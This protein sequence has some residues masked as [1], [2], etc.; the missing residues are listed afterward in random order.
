MS[1]LFAALASSQSP[2]TQ[3]LLHDSYSIRRDALKELKK[4]DEKTKAS[5][6][7]E[8]LASLTNGPTKSRS[9]AIAAI[10]EMKLPLLSA[11]PVLIKLLKDK[12]MDSQVRQQ[13]ALAL[14]KS[15]TSDTDVL[16]ALADGLKDN[17]FF[18]RLGAVT[19]L[20]WIGEGVDPLY[21]DLVK[22]TT[23]ENWQIRI[24]AAHSLGH[25]GSKAVPT[26]T[27]MLKDSD[28]T[29]SSEVIQTLGGMGKDAAS[30]VP[31]L[32]KAREFGLEGFAELVDEA[33][34]R[35]ETE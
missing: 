30:A 29:V 16:G 27:A 19:A 32:N 28:P 14:G 6:G 2:L 9:F 1:L 21:D 7:E 31:A 8:L 33:I 22:A 23:D 4:V 10:G 35:I 26:L 25:L 3:R 18:V 12:G 5:I 20:S 24:A 34:R 11:K 15:K 17:D 13:A